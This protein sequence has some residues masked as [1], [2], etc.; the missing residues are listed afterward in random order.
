M[1]T[2]QPNPSITPREIL[3]AWGKILTGKVPMLSIEI[4]RECPLQLS[5]LLRLWRRAPRRRQTSYRPERFSRRR[6]VNGVLDLV[7]K[8]QPHARL[9]G[10]GEPARPPSRIER[11]PARSQRHEYLFAGRHQRRYSHSGGMDGIVE[12]SRGHIRR[13]IAGTAYDVR[14]KPAT[15]CTIAS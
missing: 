5:G 13:R 9:A 1:T 2:A 4:T 10:R 12:S 8:H 6:V 15:Y 14:R 3:S 11:H 7:R